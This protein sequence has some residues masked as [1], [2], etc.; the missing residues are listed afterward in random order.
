[1]QNWPE[2]ELQG[3][4]FRIPRV[5]PN[6][7]APAVNE[8]PTS[9]TRARFGG[10]TRYTMTFYDCDA[11][12]QLFR[13]VQAVEKKI[14]SIG[15][16]LVAGWLLMGI[17]WIMLMGLAFGAAP[18]A[19]SGT[20]LLIATAI[21]AG[22]TF[23]LTRHFYRKRDALWNADRPP[24]P[25]NALGYG[26]AAFLTKTQGI[27]HKSSTFSAARQEWLHLLVA[28]NADADG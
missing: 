14:K 26:F 21:A 19:W 13:D 4:R 5:C 6:C 10:Q 3:K 1:M 22:L 9:Y 23:K 24:L 28:E 17:L 20:A 18:E 8:W 2:I 7:L 16:N 12:S 25:L 27:I 11:C 15:N